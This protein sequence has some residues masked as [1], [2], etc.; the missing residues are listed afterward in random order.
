MKYLIVD[1]E[2]TDTVDNAF[3]E[4]IEFGYAIVEDNKIVDK[5]GSF[6]K[7]VHGTLSYFIE[8]LTSIT[9]QDLEYAPTFDQFY[10]S[11]FTIAE[12]KDYVF[13][14]WGNYDSGM[15]DR[16]CKLW[17]LPEL[18]FAK[19]I[20]LKDE[21]KRFYGFSKERGLQRALNHAGLGF[22]GFHHRGSDDAYNTAR[23]F[24]QLV[25]KGWIIPQN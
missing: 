19:R 17:N 11:F 12:P 25:E 5:G 24:L 16:M 1:V 13:V 18:E 22:E 14:A 4:V 10:N 8:Q 7:P 6:I 3:P 23:L 20:N 15:M 9:E 2:S 21:H